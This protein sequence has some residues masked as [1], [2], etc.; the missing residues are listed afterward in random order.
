MLVKQCMI[1]DVQLGSPETTIKEAAQKMRD[2]DFGALP[3]A[4][5]DRLIGMVTDRD[6]VI[7]AVSEGKDPNSTKVIDCM[8]KQV[9][10]CYEDQTLEEVAK[11]LGDNQIRRVP[12]LS[13]E[14]RL[15][16]IVALG[17][18]AVS[19]VSP[20]KVEETLSDISQRG[21]QQKSKEDQ[22]QASD[23]SGRRQN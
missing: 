1:R 3:I 8:T 19:N 4:E 17:D 12:V 13:R 10:Y 2:G 16:G 23:N 21:N 14:K 9:L 7:R 6:I 22:Q 18:I 15:V 5:N 11:N 20:K